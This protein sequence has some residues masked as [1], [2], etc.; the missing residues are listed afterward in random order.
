[1]PDK[2]FTEIIVLLDRSG[3][4]AQIKDDMEG[5]FNKY[6]DD[7]R[8][9]DNCLLTLVQFD[10][11]GIDTVVESCPIRSAPKLRLEPRGGTPL[12]DAM[13][14]TIDRTG[15]RFRNMPEGR[16]PGQVMFVI[17]TDGEENSSH[18]YTKERVKQMVEHQS[19]VYKWEFV[20]LGANMD[21][22][23]EARDLGIYPMSVANFSSLPEHA[24]ARLAMYKKLSVGSRKYISRQTLKPTQDWTQEDRDEMEGKKQEA[25]ESKEPQ[26]N[27]KQV[28]D[29]RTRSKA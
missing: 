17:I 3:S 18:E 24:K 21:S 1:M 29:A 5:G 8:D 20:F 12:L 26:A 2:R 11:G 15:E 27:E 19:Q 25:E 4:M 6:V 16:R 23:A 14:Q 9:M 28:R 13:G 22:F 7:L 10:T